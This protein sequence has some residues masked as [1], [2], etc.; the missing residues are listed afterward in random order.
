[1]DSKYKH[2]RPLPAIDGL[3][4]VLSAHHEGHNN[5]EDE[6]AR[7][8]HRAGGEQRLAQQDIVTSLTRQQRE[9]ATSNRPRVLMRGWTVR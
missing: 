3:L 6:N 2:P 4:H 8:I 7:D 1:V 9:E 5:H